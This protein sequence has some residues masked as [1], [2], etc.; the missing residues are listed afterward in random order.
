MNHKSYLYLILFFL[1]SCVG[2]GEKFKVDEDFSFPGQEEGVISTGDSKKSAPVESIKGFHIKNFNQ[3]NMSFSK[4]TGVP[5]S[6]QNVSDVMGQILNQLPADND[7][8]SF[9][10]FHQISI[11]RL[12]FTYCEIFVDQDAEFNGLNYS[13]ISSQEITDRLISRFLDDAPDDQP[14]KYDILKDE[15]L[16]TLN[17]EPDPSA[18][19]LVDSVGV[20]SDILKRRLTK[21]ACSLTLS[22]SFVTLI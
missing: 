3:I 17:N 20:R 7:L 4:L 8:N 22:S 11:T 1:F 12:A 13:T 6:R 10:P 5:R 9:T 21:M 16:S 18:G 2:E 19:P 14:E 15:L